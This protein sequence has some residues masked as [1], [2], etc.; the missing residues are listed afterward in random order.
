MTG[1]WKTAFDKESVNEKEGQE[2][3]LIVETDE[4]IATRV[5]DEYYKLLDAQDKK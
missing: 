3:S 2:T 4:T 5:F 1:R